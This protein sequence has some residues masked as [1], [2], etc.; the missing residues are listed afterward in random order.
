MYIMDTDN[1]QTQEQQQLTE[2]NRKYLYSY[3]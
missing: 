2:K 1:K 3:S